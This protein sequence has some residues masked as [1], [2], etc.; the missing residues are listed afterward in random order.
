M[1][2]VIVFTAVLTIGENKL[3]TFGNFGQLCYYKLI[4]WLF[5]RLVIK[6]SLGL[7]PR[8]RDHLITNLPKAMV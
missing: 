8:L 6:W 3:Y 7:Y 5:G 2:S 1:Q 4:A